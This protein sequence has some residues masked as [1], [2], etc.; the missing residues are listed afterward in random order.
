MLLFLERL[1]F[2]FIGSPDVT[3][4]FA[5]NAQFASLAIGEQAL[6]GRKD[7]HAHPPENSGKMIG[8]AI[9]TK[10]GLRHPRDAAYR[11]TAILGILQHDFKRSIRSRGNFEITRS[12]SHSRPLP[13]RAMRFRS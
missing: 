11:P 3:K 12:S 5:A 7:R 8:L 6:A 1:D 10:T 4:D 13:S 9:H 2:A